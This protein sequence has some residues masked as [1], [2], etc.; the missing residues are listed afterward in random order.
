MPLSY[1]LYHKTA[2]AKKDVLGTGE[3][4][5]GCSPSQRSPPNAGQ[6]RIVE[7]QAT[8]V[9]R[10][11]WN[12]SLMDTFLGNRKWYVIIL[13]VKHTSGLIF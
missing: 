3:A 2:E 12:H 9:K 10:C 11:L 8:V 7:A 13:K 5:M 4:R 6:F 1:L